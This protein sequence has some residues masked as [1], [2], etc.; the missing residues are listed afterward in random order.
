MS[1][2]WNLTKV[3]DLDAIRDNA[4]WDGIINS[5]IWGTMIVDMGEI[6]EKNWEEFAA[7]IY[8]HQKWFGAMLV[9]TDKETGKREDFFVSPVHIKR[10]IG[11][12]T[13]VST[14]TYSKWLYRMGKLQM[15]E[16]IREVRK[17]KDE[18]S[19]A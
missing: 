2:N 12:S 6:T 17:Y 11:L 7:R 18:P 16:A 19:Y 9:Q 13:N 15:E 5:V 1:L 14:K 4:E 8:L 3:K 10:L